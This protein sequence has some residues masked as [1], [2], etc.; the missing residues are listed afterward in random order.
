MNYDYDT[1][2]NMYNYYNN[3]A[4]AYANEFGG[5]GVY[6][7]ANSYGGYPGYNEYKDAYAKMLKASQ[8]MNGRRA[9]SGGG[10]IGIGRNDQAKQLS[11]AF[12][13][14]ASS[15]RDQMKN[16]YNPSS[17]F[18]KGL[19]RPQRKRRNNSP[20][21]QIKGNS[22]NKANFMKRSQIANSLIL[23]LNL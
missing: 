21:T 4:N 3:W 15:I 18:D 14:Y 5:S 2:S 6:F 17:Y 8:A 10:G 12:Y 16:L 9:V 11:G 7:D 13:K 23:N 22:K 1:L 19:N 20:K